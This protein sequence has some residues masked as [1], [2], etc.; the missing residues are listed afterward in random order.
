MDM[1]ID[2]F[3]A[4]A[5]DIDDES[6]FLDSRAILLSRKN[7]KL[8][9]NKATTNRMQESLASNVSVLQLKHINESRN[10]TCQAQN[11][12]GLVLFNLSLVIKGN[13]LL[14]L[15]LKPSRICFF[16]FLFILWFNQKKFS[17]SFFFFDFSFLFS[18]GKKIENILS[19]VS[20]F[21]WVYCFNSKLFSNICIDK[22]EIPA[23]F[24][25]TTIYYNSIELE[26][27]P[28]GISEV[29]YYILKYRRSINELDNYEDFYEATRNDDEH[30]RNSFDFQTINTTQTKYK[31]TNTLKS[32]TFYEFKVSAGNHLGLGR[33]TN[34]LRVRTAPSSKQQ[35]FS[36]ISIYY[37]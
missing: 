34:L 26:W 24:N 36:T 37:L 6:L 21:W 16:L 14:L 3:A 17:L 23:S 30:R 29:L 20:Y 18:T 13:L 33:E 4:S 9:N 28:G 11:T 10:F 2:S 8:V 35:S 1:S 22:P 7:A 27:R 19:Q 25:V 31:V 32:F 5:T 15:F 12:I